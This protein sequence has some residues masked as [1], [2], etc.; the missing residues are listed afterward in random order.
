MKFSKECPCCG[1][2]VAAY[3][4]RL[5]KGLCE[6]LKK[7]INAYRGTRKAS[8][9]AD[10]GLSNAQY[11]SFAHLQYFGLAQRTEHGWYPT[12]KGES[13]MVNT[14]SC[15]DTVAILNNEVLPLDH[16]AW[17]THDRQ[18]RFVMCDDFLPYEYKQR[19][20]YQEEKGSKYPQLFTI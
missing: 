1:H 7:L 5:N 20:E 13:F 4:Y 9:L 8:K 6:S 14:G 12:P 2:K 11:S 3:T 15:V 17:Q 19:S 16:E 18:P 10:L